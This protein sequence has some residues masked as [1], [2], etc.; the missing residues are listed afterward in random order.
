MENN[1]IKL[2]NWSNLKPIVININNIVYIEGNP[3]TGF[4]SIVYVSTIDRITKIYVTE[5]PE[6]IYDKI[7]ILKNLPE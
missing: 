3:D 1:F 7:T 2:T 5:Y 6:V 4:N